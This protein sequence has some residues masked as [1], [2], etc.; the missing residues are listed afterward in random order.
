MKGRL[1]KTLSLRNRV[2]W[3][4]SFEEGGVPD[5]QTAVWIVQVANSHTSR[6]NLAQI[7]DESP[8]L[9]PA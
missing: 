2:L 1:A 7:G 3:R 6:A 8:F 5:L 9:S 4:R